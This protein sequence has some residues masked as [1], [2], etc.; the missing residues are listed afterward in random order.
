M[1]V[2]GVGHLLLEIDR[3]GETETRI[4]RDRRPFD[5]AIGAR[6]HPRRL[7]IVRL[8]R[9]R[10]R[11]A[12]LL[13][14]HRLGE[15]DQAAIL[16]IVHVDVAGLAGVQDARERS[17]RPCPSHRPG[18]SGSWHRGPT[19]HGRCT[20]SSRPACRY[21]DRPKP[22]SPYRGCRRAAASR[23]D[24]ARDCRPR[25]RCA[26]W[27]GRPTGFC[28]TPPPSVFVGIAGLGELRLFRRDV[29]MHVAAGGVLGRPHAD[30]ILR[31]RR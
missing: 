1:R 28:H 29:A 10:Q 6:E 12:V 17:C 30:R 11:P 23:R 5:A 9:G 7:R 16:A 31:N 24:R 13:R 26:W 21:R 25:N 4:G 14:H 22:A 20:G 8:G 19:G 27:R 3:V 2:D 15:A 18:P